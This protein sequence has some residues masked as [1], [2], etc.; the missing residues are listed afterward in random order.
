MAVMLFTHSTNY[1]DGGLLFY[2]IFTAE[3]NRLQE[4]E[5]VQEGDIRAA[6]RQIRINPYTGSP[7][8]EQIRIISDYLDVQVVIK[9]TISEMS[10]KM[11]QGK[12][13]PSMTVKLD[14]IDAKTGR[15]LSIVHHRRNGNDYLKVM[16]FGVVTTTT[17][18]SH[19]ISQEIIEDWTSKGFVATCVK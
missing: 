8:S 1:R 15:T 17:Q 12:S 18:L 10:E 13:V 4:F 7:T 19:L 3:L 14:L 6:Y 16:H 9:G 11:V 2:R 5:T